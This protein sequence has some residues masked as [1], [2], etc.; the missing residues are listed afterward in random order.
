MPRMSQT[1]AMPDGSRSIAEKVRVTVDWK[2]E[3]TDWDRAVAKFLLATVR[4]ESLPATVS[5]IAA[6][7][8]HVTTDGAFQASPMG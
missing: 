3:P 2:A 1:P 6:V 7:S 5:P 4:K 8:S